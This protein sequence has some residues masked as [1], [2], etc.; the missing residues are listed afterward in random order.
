MKPASPSTPAFLQAPPEPADVKLNPAVEIPDY[1]QETYWWAYLHPRGV[2]F[3]DRTWM[4]NSIL[5]GNFRKLRDAAV[6]ELGEDS[7]TTL[8]VAA[9][10]GDITP[11]MADKLTVKNRLDVLDVA[12]VQLKNVKRKVEHLPNVRLLHADSTAMPQQDKSY[13]TIVVFFLLHEQ[14]DAQKR[15]TLQEVTRL[16][17]PGGRIIVVDYHKPAWWSPW[18][19]FMVPGLKWLE[20]FALSLWPTEII[21]WFPQ[22]LPVKSLRK[23]TVFA[24]LYQ[25]VVIDMK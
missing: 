1:L 3:F 5:F 15:Q 14:P 12:P 10:Y 17:R 8:Q 18:R 7:G 23:S 20:P 13:D 11:R 24:G 21:D 16:I 19:W 9:V 6:A 4:V 25:K 22:E 2:K